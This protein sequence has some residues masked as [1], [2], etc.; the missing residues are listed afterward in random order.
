M[1]KGTVGL[2]ALIVTGAALAAP[3]SYHLLK[4]IPVPG[5]GGWD[6]VFVDAAA[7]RVYVSH[8]TQ[9]DVLDADSGDR[10]GKIGDTAGVH[11][12]TVA[13]GLGRGFTSNGRSNSVTIFDVQSLKPLGT[14][15]TGRNPDCIIYEPVTRRVFAFNGGGASATVIEAADGKVAGTIA[16]EGKPEFAAADTKGHVFVN[17]E[18]KNEVVRLDAR[19]MKVLDRWPVAPGKTPVSLAMDTANRRV[20]IGCRSKMLVVMDAD[21]GKVV[22]TGPIGE[23]VDAGAYD[24]ETKLVFNSCGDGTVSVFRQDSPDTYSPM[25]TIKTR[26]G[27]KTMGLDPKTH[28]LFLPAVEYKAAEPGA[29]KA[30]PTPVPGSFAVLVFGP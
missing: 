26:P 20:F 22:A 29:P 13:P 25:A 17:L 18:D 7:R 21:T 8:A 6:Y 14:V 9:V 11:G 16:L 19:N 10:K 15:P 12:I 28:R 1:F 4:T 30:R 3:E 27:S 23:R 2:F 24:P 5:D